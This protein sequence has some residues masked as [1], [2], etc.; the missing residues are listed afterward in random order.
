M[1]KHHRLTLP[2]LILVFLVSLAFISG[3]AHAGMVTGPGGGSPSPYTPGSGGGGSSVLAHAMWV[4]YWIDDPSQ[5]AKISGARSSLAD[6][7]TV[8]DC[9]QYGGFYVLQVMNNG[10]SGKLWYRSMSGATTV[11]NVLASWDEFYIPPEGNWAIANQSPKKGIYNEDNTNVTPYITNDGKYWPNGSKDCNTYGNSQYWTCNNP[12]SYGSGI[13]WMPKWATIKSLFKSKNGGTTQCTIGSWSGDCFGSSSPLAYFCYGK[14]PS[15]TFTLSYNKNTT[16]SVSGMPSS[17][18]CTTTDNSC[19]V[20]VSSATPSRTGY[21]FSGWKNGSGTSYSAGNTSIS[22]NVTLYAQWTA[23]DYATF[24]GSVA[25]SSSNLKSDSTYDFRGNGYD[26]SY[27][28]TSTY[29][30]T[31]TNNNPSSATSRFN[32]STSSY[33]TS[34]ALTTSALTNNSSYSYPVDNSI[35]VANGATNNYCFYLSYDDKV[36]YNGSSIKEQHFDGRASKCVSIYNPNKYVATFSGSIASV[37]NGSGLSDNSSVADGKIGN[38]FKSQ[39]TLTPTYN[40]KRTNNS[41]TWAVSSQYA[42]SDSSQ[43]TS[44]S[45]TSNSMT[46]NQSQDIAGSAKNVIVNIGGTASQCFY[47]SYDNQVIYIDSVLDKRVFSGRA[48]RCFSFTNPAKTHET[49]FSAS[50]T[51]VIDAHDKLTRTDNNHKGY[52]N[53]VKRRSGTNSDNDGRYVDDFPANSTYTTTFKHTITRT[54]S[55]T[56]AYSVGGDYT[57]SSATVPYQVQQYQ[58]NETKRIYEWTNISGKSGTLSLAKDASST[59]ESNPSFTLNINN[60]GKYIYYCQRVAYRPSNTYTTTTDT[61]HRDSH[62]DSPSYADWAYTSAVCI[63]IYNPKWTE[64]YVRTSSGAIDYLTHN[65]SVTGNTTNVVPSGAA[66]TSGNLNGNANFEATGFHPSF[67]YGHTLK[68]TDSGADETD[69]IFSGKYFQPSIYNN[70]AYKVKTSMW[71]SET[72]IRSSMY[73]VYPY[74]LQNGSFTTVNGYPVSFGASNKNSGDSWSSGD[75]YSNRLEGRTNTIFNT[76]S[77]RG[78]TTSTRNAFLYSLLANGT[79][80]FKQGTYNTRAAWIVRYQ[81][82]QRKGYCDNPSYVVTSN[83]F[84]RIEKADAAPVATAPAISDPASAYH[85][86]SIYRPYNFRITSIRPGQ[87]SITSS[88]IAYAGD[89]F[90]IK[91]NITV[92]RNDTTHAFITDPNHTANARYVYPVVYTLPNGISAASAG[93]RTHEEANVASPCAYFNSIATSCTMLETGHGLKLV[94]AEDSSYKPT[95][96]DSDTHF[97]HVYAGYGNGGNTYKYT[98]SYTTGTITVPTLHVGEKFCVALAVRNYSSTSNNFFISASTCRNISKNPSLQAHGGSVISGG[99]IITSQSAYNSKLFGSWA[100]FAVTASKEPIVR[101][102]SGAS[103]LGGI[104]QNATTCTKSP[105]TIT[106]RQCPDNKLGDSSVYA[107]TELIKKTL[108]YFHG[109]SNLGAIPGGVITSGTHIVRS[110]TGITINRD[111]ITNS[112]FPYGSDDLPQV[113]IIAPSIN[114]TSNVTRIDAWLIATGNDGYGGNIDTCSDVAESDLSAS[115]CERQLVINGALSGSKIFFKRTANGD[116]SL[117]NQADSA[118]LVNYDPSTIIWGTRKA[119]E[120]SVPSIVYLKKLP[121]RY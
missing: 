115:V 6:D 23:L 48:S 19:T 79:K 73:Q 52:I 62:I 68:R 98:L 107:R 27:T 12:G 99:G 46:H 55:G 2:D 11:A 30:I 112:T 39:F 90:D 50:S 81:K 15:K 105:L 100:D 70:N 63:T 110:T 75:G 8:S 34:S 36:G 96:G 60:R 94:A 84:D 59:I 92:D 29:K 109:G 17:T 28:L 66:L 76:N 108:E 88:L 37:A 4:Y 64:D 18:S 49:T 82:I 120:N 38:G 40:I 41:P 72:G 113:I 104:A 54:D 69:A 65:I 45:S 3:N 31:R 86:Y 121:P 22:D 26:T 67:T 51:G 95:D 9:G 111:I 10:P 87:S 119:T 56:T 102:A 78:N 21:V 25:V 35:T 80:N 32:Y 106:N 13:D 85:S 103:M 14:D 114:I 5:S 7:L 89:T 77:A 20:T 16:D 93:T 43:P 47:I 116:P 24:S 118:E 117:N 101:M 83:V 44:S 91:Y 74:K 97:R 71:G 61:Q 1:S 42:T 53:N 57:I 58:Y 33:P